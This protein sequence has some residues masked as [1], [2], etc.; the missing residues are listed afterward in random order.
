MIPSNQ[1]SEIKKSIK[2]SN[3]DINSKIK[4]LN[5]ELEKLKAQISPSKTLSKSALPFV[6]QNIDIW[7][8]KPYAQV[9]Q[10]NNRTMVAYLGLYQRSGLWKVVDI[11]APSQSV[12]FVN[13]KEQ[14]V[15]V[16][17]KQF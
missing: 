1:I 15:H 4:A 13:N 5:G 7:N 8:G 2:S 14:I 11:S 10:R 12:T 17:V 3:T 9:A 6:V 16:S